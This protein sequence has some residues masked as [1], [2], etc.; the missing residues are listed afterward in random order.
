[1]LACDPFEYGRALFHKFSA[2]AT[3]LPSV[4]ALLDHIRV[5]GEQAPLDG[6]LIHSHWYQTNKPATAF[7]NIQALIVIQ[8]RLIR[9]LN[10]FVAFVHP[11]H[12]GRSVCKFVN[13]LM[14]S[15]WVLSQTTCSFSDFGDLVIGGAYIIVGVHDSTQSWT[16]PIS[17][18]IPPS[19]TSLP[20]AAYIWQPFNKPEYSVSFAKDDDSFLADSNNGVMATIPSLLVLASLP[21]GIKP[22]YYLHLRDLNTATLAGV[23]VLSLDSLCPAFDGLP[24]PNL[25]RCW[26]GIEF[27][28]DDHTHVHAIL[29][30]KFTSCFGLT[31]HLW[32]PLSQHINWYALDAGI[33]ALTL[34]WIFDHIH[35]R[36]ATIWDSNTKIFL[37]NKYATPAAHIQAFVGGVVATRIPNCKRWVQAIVSDPEL[38]KIKDIVSNPSKL[39]NKALAGINY[40]HHAALRKSLIVL[41]DDV[42]IYQEP[43]AG[44]GS[45]TCLQL[46]PQE[47]HNILFITFHTNPVGGHLNPYCTL[48]RLRLWYYWPGMYSYVKRMC[49]ACPRCALSNPTKAKSSKLVYNFPIEAPFMVLHVNAYMA[50]AHSGFKGS[51]TYIVACCGMCSFGALEP[52]TGAN[53]TTFA[54]AIM[55]IQLWYGFCHTIVLD[56]DSKFFGVCWE[57]LDLL[58]INCHILSGDNHNP[59]LV[60]RICCYFNKGLTIMCNER[61]T[62]RVALESLLLLLYAWNSCPV[63]GTDISRSL[64]AVGRKFAFPIDYSSGK[65]WQLTSSPAT[66]ERYSKQLATHLSACREIA[67]LLVREHRDW[68]RALVNSCRKDPRVYS[69]GDIVF[70]RRA[71]CSDASC[72]RVGKLE[73]KFTGPWRI[74]ESLHGGSH[75]HEHCLHPKRTEKKHASDLTPYPPEL[76]PLKPVNGAD[77]HYG[78]LY[79]PIGEHPFK[80]AGLKGFTPPAPF[81]VANLFLDIGDFK[82]FRWPTLLELNDK[83][84]PYPWRD[85]EE[86][87]R[88][89]TDDPPF[90]PQVMY[91][92]PPP[93]PPKPAPQS[94]SPPT[95]TELAPCIIASTDKLFFIAYAI[96]EAKRKWC[97]VR[98]AF[99][100]SISLYP[101]A[102][103]DGQFLVE[104]YVLHPANIRYNATNQQYW[105]QYCTRNGVFHGHLNAHLIAPLD[106][107]EEHATRH[108]LLPIHCW[109]NLTHADT[110]IHGPFGFATVNGCK[111][112]D[113]VGQEA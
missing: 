25:F 12:N 64:V 72:E 78:Q 60:K 99:N 52:V 30:F 84:D 76:I 45:Y 38:C 81:Q 109:V 20:L 46:G 89:M 103:Q 47:F 108:H 35:K 113:P 34:A 79:H 75:S 102:L 13:Q 44:S 48:H 74:L 24:N 97:L 69:P 65:Y 73:Y 27:N 41:E 16:E 1:M 71:T 82:D 77:T 100:E 31:D 8:L 17:F 3:V 87:R 14:S 67:E 11:D 53:A 93:S 107:S 36:L 63:P 7:W 90:S 49:S 110:Y 95:I 33:P 70:A 94:L 88:F 26:F 83:L 54:S 104:F 22:L 68:H 19:P 6:Y 18:C 2:W 10:L 39:S 23:A 112:W 15:G 66:V 85:D 57:A 80:D 32:Y 9:Q 92:G 96:G 58:K 91:T 4:G 28:A 62:V 111:T 105:L 21:D 106:T 51:K 43:L 98:V 40:N 42:L 56:K 37:P 86:R 55:K 29:P 5:S 50:G 61:D 59:M 101:S